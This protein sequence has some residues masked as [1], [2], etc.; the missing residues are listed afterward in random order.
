MN[1][2]S[3]FT[4]ELQLPVGRANYNFW[5]GERTREPDERI[6]ASGGASVLASRK[7]TAARQ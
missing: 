7:A 4:S 6:T 1:G 5:W 2:E 3:K